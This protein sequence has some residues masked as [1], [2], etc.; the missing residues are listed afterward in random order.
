MIP[1]SEILQ[2]YKGL[3]QHNDHLSRYRDIHN[4]D[5]I[6]ALA[7]GCSKSSALAMELLQYCTE[8]SKYLW[9]N[10]IFVMGNPILVRQDVSF[11]MAVALFF[12]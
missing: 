4:K 1:D 11:E 10:L 2:S 8:S 12:I 6:D 3:F 7:Q 9:K 5:K